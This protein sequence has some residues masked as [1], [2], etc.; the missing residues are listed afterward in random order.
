MSEKN[1][2]QL[3]QEMGQ[4]LRFAEAELRRA[5][6]AFLEALATAGDEQDQGN[7]GQDDEDRPQHG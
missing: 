2:S 7:D 3:A 4:A 5:L 6:D 1:W